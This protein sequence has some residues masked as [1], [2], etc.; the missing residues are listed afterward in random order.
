MI[1][2]DLLQQYRVNLLELLQ[3]VLQSIVV[4]GSQLCLRQGSPAPNQIVVLLQIEN[5]VLTGVVHFVVIE[6]FLDHE[7]HVAV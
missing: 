3:D 1:V 5:E 7:C 2:L 6:P 4:R